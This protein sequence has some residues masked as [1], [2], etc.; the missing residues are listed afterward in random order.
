MKGYTAWW[1][2]NR[3]KPWRPIGE[4]ETESAAWELAFA[5]IRGGDKC[6][7]QTGR[8][9]NRRPGKTQDAALVAAAVRARQAGD[10]RTEGR[11]RRELEQRGITVGLR[12]QEQG[13]EQ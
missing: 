6:V 11:L 1:R 10:A 5:R 9:P 12:E 3:R 13:V 7:L 2:E 4:A 8:D